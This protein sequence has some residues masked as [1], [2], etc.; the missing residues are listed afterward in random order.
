MESDVEVLVSFDE[1]H[2]TLEGHFPKNP[3]IPGAVILNKVIKAAENAWPNESDGA[4][5]QVLSCKFLQPLV[6]P[7]IMTIFLQKLHDNKIKF[8]TKNNAVTLS[9]GIIKLSECKDDLSEPS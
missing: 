5:V 3:L 1:N 9:S 2:P 4:S 8:V 6:P 7:A